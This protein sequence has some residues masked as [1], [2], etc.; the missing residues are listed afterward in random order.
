MGCKDIRNACTAIASFR[1]ARTAQN[2]CGIPAAEASDR[3]RLWGASDSRLF[4]AADEEVRL[5]GIERAR[6]G[7]LGRDKSAS[8]QLEKA[9]WHAEEDAVEE[10]VKQAAAEVTS[11]DD[12]SP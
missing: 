1:K 4:T 3:F 8:R 7:E 6:T 9:M 2:S 11:T 10:M 12:F 5:R